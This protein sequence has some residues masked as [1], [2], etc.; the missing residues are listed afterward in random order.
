MFDKEQLF[1][2]RVRARNSYPNFAFQTMARVPFGMFYVEV[3]EG[4]RARVARNGA[5]AVAP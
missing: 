2:W 5:A 4:R 1:V 3:R